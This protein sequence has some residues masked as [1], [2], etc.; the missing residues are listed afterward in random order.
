MEYAPIVRSLV[1]KPLFLQLSNFT[2]TIKEHVIKTEK[3]FFLHILHFAVFSFFFL[4][5]FIRLQTGIERERPVFFLCLLLL[6]LIPVYFIS[7]WQ[8]NRFFTKRSIPFYL[9]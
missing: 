9:R 3:Y 2:E 4:I 1:K 5:G 6:A 8:L 7:Q